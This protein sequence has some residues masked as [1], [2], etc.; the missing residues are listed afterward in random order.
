[1]TP[2][3]KCFGIILAGGLSRRM[4]GGD[5]ALSKLGGT[6]L[7]AR[8]IAALRPQCEG[9]VL[10]A[11][12]DPARFADFGFPIIADDVPG[13]KGPLAGILAGFDWIARHV[14]DVEFAISAPADTPFLPGDLTARLE[15]ARAGHGAYIACARSGGRTHP[16]V[17][18]WPVAIRQDLRH[19]LVE[20][21]RRKAGDFLQNTRH[22]LVDWPVDPFDPFFN[23]NE[24]GDLA[25]AE[26]MLARRETHIA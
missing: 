21:D 8:V 20:E 5:K 18:L 3:G 10:S 1:L 7:L 12:G 24:P 2:A 17:A 25:A 26:S 6:S 11:N 16:L 4:G 14:P 19:A 23:V 22:A 9:L 13:F 15:D